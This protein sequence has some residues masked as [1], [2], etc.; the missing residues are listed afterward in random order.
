MFYY[1]VL[2]MFV[3]SDNKI[4]NFLSLLQ[5]LI[6]RQADVTRNTVQKCVCV[7]SEL[8]NTNCKINEKNKHTFHEQ[9]IMIRL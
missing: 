9:Q 7:L 3:V 2:L 8:V 6:N 4:K 1:C 5:E